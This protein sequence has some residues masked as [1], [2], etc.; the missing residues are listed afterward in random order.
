MTGQMFTFSLIEIKKKNPSHSFHN[1]TTFLKQKIVLELFF[2]RASLCPTQS[3]ALPGFRDMAYISL[4]LS[5]SHQKKPEQGCVQ[6]RKPKRYSLFQPQKAQGE[7]AGE[8]PWTSSKLNGSQIS[9]CRC[10]S[11]CWIPANHPSFKVMRIK[12]FKKLI[13]LRRVIF[14]NTQR[15][16]VTESN[17]EQ[18]EESLVVWLPVGLLL[19]I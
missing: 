3:T 15:E 16:S 10:H 9:Q 6:F 11:I 4:V 18:V 14:A 7:G 5:L 8:Q 1:K 2:S 13:W 17:S 19:P 12:Q